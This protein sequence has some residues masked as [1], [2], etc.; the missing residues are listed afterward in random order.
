MRDRREGSSAAD[1]VADVTDVTDVTDVS[2]MEEGRREMGVAIKV[3]ES[4]VETAVESQTFVSRCG[5]NKLL[6]RLKIGSKASP[7]RRKSN[8]MIHCSNPLLSMEEI[9]VNGCILIW[10]GGSISTDNLLVI[11]RDLLPKCFAPTSIFAKMGCSR[12]QLS[13]DEEPLQTHFHKG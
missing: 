2:P 13:T 3:R 11:T 1:F 10:K 8:K 6:L 4:A 5:L 7:F 9:A 12:C